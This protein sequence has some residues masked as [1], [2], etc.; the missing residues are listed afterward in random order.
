MTQQ[1]VQNTCLFRASINFN[2]LLS[3]PITHCITL[4]VAKFTNS[5]RSLLLWPVDKS[6]FIFNNA[7]FRINLQVYENDRGNIV[8][9][10]CEKR[11]IEDMS[12]WLCCKQQW[13]KWVHV[14]S[15]S[16]E[17]TTTTTKPLLQQ[18]LLIG[19]MSKLN[20]LTYDLCDDITLIT[21]ILNNGVEI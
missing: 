14:V 13:K 11:L 12:H 7:I 1:S 19:R 15:A 21:V 3:L 10:I 20:E 18:Q 6:Q 2:T 4:V 8:A 5:N 17:I 16:T 9:A